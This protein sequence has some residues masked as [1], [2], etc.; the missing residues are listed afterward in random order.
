MKYMNFYFKSALASSGL[1]EETALWHFK[2]GT[3]SLESTITGHMQRPWPSSNF[4]LKVTEFAARWR[5][6]EKRPKLLKIIIYLKLG[7]L[8]VKYSKRGNA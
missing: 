7:K 2:F 5:S 8:E 4:P 6:K 3:Q 1:G